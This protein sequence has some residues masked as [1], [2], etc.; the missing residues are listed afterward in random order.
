MDH[1]AIQFHCA[2]L[3]YTLRHKNHIRQWIHRICKKHGYQI[4]QLQFVFCTDDYLLEIN[5]QFLQHD[6]FTDIIT[7][8]NTSK[9]ELSIEAY[10]SID[11]VKDNA[12][13]LRLPF[14]Q[15][16]HR[17]MIHGVL[18]GLGFKDKTKK[19]TVLMRS[20]EDEALKLLETI[21]KA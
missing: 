14:T 17:V 12:H 11:R 1:V 8:D 3:S 10:I 6:Y 21:I 5:R 2:D 19:D 7:F 16:L 4:G 18:H 9:K 15:E 20:A 13:D